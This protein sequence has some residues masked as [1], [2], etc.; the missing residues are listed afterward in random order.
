MAWHFSYTLLYRVSVSLCLFLFCIQRGG[1]GAAQGQERA[2]RS[3]HGQASEAENTGGGRGREWEIIC[4]RDG[5]RVPT[6]TDT[7]TRIQSRSNTNTPD[8]HHRGQ[9][10]RATRERARSG[11]PQ[12]PPFAE[13][14]STC[15]L[16]PSSRQPVSRAFDSGSLHSFHF[17]LFT[18]LTQSA[19]PQWRQCPRCSCHSSP[20]SSRSVRGVGW[21]QRQA[22]ALIGGKCV[23]DPSL[24][25]HHSPCTYLSRDGRDARHRCRPLHRLHRWLRPDLAVSR[26]ARLG[27]RHPHRGRGGE[28]ERG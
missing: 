3:G 14:L 10:T 6:H 26:P 7:H 17:S 20:A 25:L 11:Q 22:A 9:T 18:T 12:R 15:Q 23:S 4:S 19:T 2:V 27:A 16:A 24:P 8:R 5:A 1:P 13:Q 21:V 28:G